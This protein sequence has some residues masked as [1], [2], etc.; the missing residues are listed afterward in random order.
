MHVRVRN[1][2]LARA[3]EMEKSLTACLSNIDFWMDP[4]WICIFALF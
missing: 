1:L 3:V 2:E 4:I